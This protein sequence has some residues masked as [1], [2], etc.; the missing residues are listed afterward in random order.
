V[1]S[2]CKVCEIEDF[3]PGPVADAIR[4][5]FPHEI[6][7]FGPA[8]PANAAYRKPWEVAM[9]ALALRAGGVLQPG[10]TALGIGAG[11][12]PTLFWLTRWMRVH[13]TD[14]YLDAE[15]WAE[16]ANA[17]MLV[18]PGHHW[19][20]EWEPQRLVV[21]H[22]DARELRYEDESF[23]A[24]FSSS[25]LEHFGSD[26]EIGQSLDEMFRVLK[27]GGV[28]S[29]STEYRI[30]GAASGLPGVRMFDAPELQR[31]ILDAAPWELM[32]ELDLSVSPATRAAEQTFELAASDVRAHVERYGEIVFHELR[33]SR[34]PHIILRQDDLAWTSVHI[35]LRKPA[36]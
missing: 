23:D 17:S 2:L 5:I 26:A 30:A 8:F 19:P 20:G 28:C 34:Y 9:A 24:V 36:R 31:L 33:F 18:D 10:R 12:E 22:M 4:E 32:D 13:A 21:Q 35:A 25:S 7:R 29:L 6:E 16:S 15:D 11:N 14:L 3:G 27:P 1:T